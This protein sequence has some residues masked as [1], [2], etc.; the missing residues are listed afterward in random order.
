[1]P[2]KISHVL[3]QVSLVAE[4]R[5][6]G[7]SGQHNGKFQRVAKENGDNEEQTEDGLSS[8]FEDELL[9]AL[10]QGD[11][12]EGEG[13]NKGTKAKAIGQGQ[14]EEE[15]SERKT[16]K[17]T[18]KKQAKTRQ[19]LARKKSRSC[20]ARAR[21]TSPMEDGDVTEVGTLEVIRLIDL[22]LDCLER[23]MTRLS[24]KD[25]C[26]VSQMCRLLKTLASS[27]PLWKALYHA[28]WPSGHDLIEHDETC[29]DVLWKEIYMKHDEEEI[30][31]RQ[32][33]NDG[34]GQLYL[35]MARA[36]RE[37]TLTDTQAAKTICVAGSD[38]CIPG[39]VSEHVQKFKVAHGIRNL[40]IRDHTCEYVRLIR[41]HWICR[42]CG[43][44]HTCGEACQEIE[45]CAGD[46][47]M[48]CRLT[49]CCSRELISVDDSKMDDAHVDMNHEDTGMNGRLGRAFFAGYN[50]SDNKE[51]MQRFGIS[52]ED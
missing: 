48:V 46:N 38:I 21:K 44:V 22:P 26:C 47:M 51:M 8:S 4:G 36:Y 20:H 39:S 1:M 5:A 6:G 42:Y 13:K 32:K 16:K 17:R 35:Q 45:R 25:L 49:G 24:P 40:G 27:Q 11:G 14:T 9:Q 28:R 52:I 29:D 19:S 50:A 15:S 43:S 33:V 10:L 41:H 37:H 23:I 12:Q 7:S 30:E 34:Q 18:R 3:P 2:D 31:K